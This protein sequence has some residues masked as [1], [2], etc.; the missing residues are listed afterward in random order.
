MVAKSR[1]M[2]IKFDRMHK[3]MKC[4]KKHW[5][6]VLG[7]LSILMNSSPFLTSV[8]WMLRSWSGTFV[9]H[10]ISSIIRPT[11]CWV[12]LCHLQM[13]FWNHYAHYFMYLMRWKQFSYLMDEE[14]GL[15]KDEVT[16][17]EDT[18]TA[19]AL[20]FWLRIPPLGNVD[21]NGTRADFLCPVLR[22]INRRNGDY[23]SHMWQASKGDS[24]K[25]SCQVE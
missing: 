4:E 17:P 9:T 3:I 1:A 24:V 18:C 2:W 19:T 21:A 25:S 12:R 22:L 16:M 5:P 6:Q 15:Q 8:S 20:Q 10:V 11:V 23:P 7:I 14:T 13:F